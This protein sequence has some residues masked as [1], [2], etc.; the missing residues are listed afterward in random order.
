MKITKKEHFS[1]MCYSSSAII[2]DFLNTKPFFFFFFKFKY[3][4]AVSQL[5][6]EYSCKIPENRLKKVCFPHGNLVKS[7]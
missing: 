2:N 3:S 7:E 6:L 4:C 5:N 1:P